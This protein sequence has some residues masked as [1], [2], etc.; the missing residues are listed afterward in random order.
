MDY[1]IIVFHAGK[2]IL[3]L[4]RLLMKN[5]IPEL[6]SVIKE[7]ESKRCRICQTE[8]P[9][10]RLEAINTDTCINCSQEPKKVCYMDYYHKTA[11]EMVVVSGKENIRRAE[12]VF[13]RKR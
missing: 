3:D 2:F 6:K 8:I 7:S 11:P 4:I 5:D 9:K 12:R 1:N 13:R 10:E